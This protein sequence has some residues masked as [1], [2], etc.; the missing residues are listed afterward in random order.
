MRVNYSNPAFLRSSHSPTNSE[1]KTT[2]ISGEFSGYSSDR[3]THSRF[4]VVTVLHRDDPIWVDVVGGNS[5]E[6]LNL[7]RVPRESEMRAKLDPERAAGRVP[8]E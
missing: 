1:R 3:S 6:H 7:A 4:E 8:V 5:N 2:A